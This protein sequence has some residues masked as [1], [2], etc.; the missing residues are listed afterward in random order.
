MAFN[1]QVTCTNLA[2]YAKNNLFDGIDVE[3]DDDNG[4][5]KNGE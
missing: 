5:T 2:N 4:F 3:F 1:A